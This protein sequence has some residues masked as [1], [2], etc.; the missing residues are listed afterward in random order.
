[1]EVIRFCA[2]S[3]IDEQTREHLLTVLNG[4]LDWPYLVRAADMHGVVPLLYRGLREMDSASVP[5]EVLN[6]LQQRCVRS[7]AYSTLLTETLLDLLRLLAEHNI[8]AVP[9]KGPILAATVYEY[10]ALR[11]FGDLDIMVRR[12]D[13]ARTVELLTSTGYRPCSKTGRSEVLAKLLGSRLRKDAGFV[14]SDGMVFVELHWDFLPEARSFPLRPE[15]AWRSCEEVMLAGAKV[16]TFATEHVLMFL[17]A[18]GAK[19]GWMYLKWI[20]DVAELVRAQQNLDWDRAFSEARRLRSERLLR[21]G[22]QLAVDLLGAPLPPRAQAYIDGDRKAKA[23]AREVKER[24]ISGRFNTERWEES[25]FWVRSREAARDRAQGLLFYL[26]RSVLNP[27]TK[28]E[29]FV[30]LPQ[31]LSFLYVL[32]R[33][34]RLIMERRTAAAD[35]EKS[36]SSDT[37]AAVESEMV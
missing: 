35:Q 15:Y 17:C 25:L 14:R 2:R 8:A 20:C 10:P 32:V 31:S 30:S 36:R 1:M 4:Q 18:H 3:Y 9:I 5:N 24:I 11:A 26:F 37:M 12:K 16:Q 29:A 21:L 27:T 28:D 7:A 19:H 33:P 6:F 34:V 23:L 13:V 22:L